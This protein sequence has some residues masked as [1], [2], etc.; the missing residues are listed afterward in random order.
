M[1]TEPTKSDLDYGVAVT[2]RNGNVRTCGVDFTYADAA[3][4]REDLTHLTNTSLDIVRLELPVNKW[5]DI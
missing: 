3:Y 2:H 5:R 4:Y 1:V